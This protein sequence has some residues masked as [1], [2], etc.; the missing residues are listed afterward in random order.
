MRLPKEF[1]GDGESAV[2]TVPTP[3]HR[4]LPP[5]RVLQPLDNRFASTPFL[6][7][8]YFY[9]QCLQPHRAGRADTN[10]GRID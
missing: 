10:T 8:S 1:K 7:F 5:E 4:Q 3:A 6:I 2:G 9:G